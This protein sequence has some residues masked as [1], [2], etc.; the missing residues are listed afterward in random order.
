MKTSIKQRLRLHLGVSLSLLVILSSLISYWFLRESADTAYDRTL[1]AIARTIGE[2]MTLDEQQQLSLRVPYLALDSFSYDNAGRIFYQVLDD[3]QQTLS[4]YTDLPKASASSQRTERYPALAKFYDA[5]YREQPVR[6]VSFMQPVGSSMFEIRVA[7]TEDERFYFSQSM[8]TYSSI[9]LLVI[10]ALV[11]ITVWLSIKYALAPLDNLGKTFSQKNLKRLKPI[12]DKDIVK[13]LHPVIEAINTY[14]QR[15]QQQLVNQSTFLS[16]TAHQLRTPIAILQG[17]LQLFDSPNLTDQQRQQ[18]QQAKQQTQLLTQQINQLL[19]LARHENAMQLFHQQTQHRCSVNQ[20]VQE[21]CINLAPN[22]HQQ[23]LTLSYENLG[24]LEIQGNPLLL[25]ELLYCL[26]ENVRMHAHA[27][28]LWI[29]TLAPNKLQIEDDGIGIDPSLYKQVLARFFQ[30][31]PSHKGT[32]LGLAIAKD[33]CTAHDAYIQLKTGAQGGLLV[34]ITFAFPVR[35][36]S[37]T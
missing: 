18:L 13:E 17:Q 14:T 29:R 26:I 8:F 31:N 3:Q 4:G 10:L 25:R 32:G 19:E 12:S 7:E 21:T 23:Q 35:N 2:N 9:R 34:E 6:V 33:I 28:H 37:T 15:L 27:K 5:R 16:N 11:I 22:L 24:K 30:V 36:I 20:L 1:L